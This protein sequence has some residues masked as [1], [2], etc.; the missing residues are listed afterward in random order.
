MHEEHELIKKELFKNIDAFINEIDL[1]MNYLDVKIVPSAE[2]YI[3]SIKTDSVAFLSFI[4]YTMCHLK[5]HQEKISVVLFSK[6]KLKSDYYNFLNSIILFNNILHL[7]VF[8]DE[9][10]ATKKDIIKY[11]YS[12]YMSVVFLSNNAEEDLTVKLSEFVKQI[13]EEASNLK[14]EDIKQSNKIKKKYNTEL[15]D[16]SILSNI[17]SQNNTKSSDLTNLISQVSQNNTESPDFSNLANF[18]LPDNL[19][20]LM[21]SI[22][23]NK[24]ILDI[25]SNI[26]KKM[27]NQQLNPMD[28]LTSLMTGNLENSPLQSLVSEI[29]QSVE[30]KIINGELNKDELETQA[31][32]MMSSISENN[33]SMSSFI[34]NMTSKN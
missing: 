24:S 33:P 7:K 25:A 11:L 27:Q 3:K 22:L 9:S 17:I 12:I 20:G 29:Q 8:Q 28:M 5:I 21:D 19:S 23:G 1:T 34:N 14:V 16:F 15:P 31:K 10:K 30:T 13:K 32:N 4:E 6:K 2:K 26:S 18:K